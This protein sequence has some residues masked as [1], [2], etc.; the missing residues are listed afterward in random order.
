M[1]TSP[2]RSGDATLVQLPMPKR[3]ASDAA[4][5][6][7]QKISIEEERQDGAERPELLPRPLPKLPGLAAG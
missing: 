6:L 3:E 7:C 4:M 2:D 5:T 1:P